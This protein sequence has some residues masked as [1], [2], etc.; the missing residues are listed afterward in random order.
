MIIITFTSKSNLD[1]AEEP[2]N[3]I[4]IK[5]ESEPRTYGNIQIQTFSASDSKATKETEEAI[6]FAN[7]FR[8]QRRRTSVRKMIARQQHLPAIGYSKRPRN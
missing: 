1:Q 3:V 5:G 2:V 4:K 8:G 7:R 6:E